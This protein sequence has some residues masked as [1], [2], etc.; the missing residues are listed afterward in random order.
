M[1][2]GFAIMRHMKTLENN[3][4]NIKRAVEI[5]RQGGVVAH[6]ADTCY[7][8]VGD[9]MNEAALKKLQKI[10]GRDAQ[11][12][13]SIMLPAYMK[14]Q[15][16][17]F[18]SL[19]DF[20]EMVCKKLL[21]GPI[22]IVLPKGSKIPNYFF[23]EIKTVGIRIP[24]DILTDDLLTKFRGPLITT[25]ANLSDQ[26]VSCQTQE[27]MTAFE[28]VKSQPDLVLAGTTQGLCMPSTV[29]SLENNKVSI[30]REGPLKK[31]QLEAILGVSI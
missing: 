11:K 1:A 13:M 30:L 24:Y 2:T 15:L 23:H 14:P 17:D 3:P 31:E 25:S 27:V 9:L 16:R 29:I 21:P 22:T 12:P 28:G 6:P 7:G 10:K 5:L 19:T 8:L 26:P 18:V 20:S 4:E